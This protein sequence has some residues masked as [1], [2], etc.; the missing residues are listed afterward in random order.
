[1]GKVYKV[2]DQ[3]QEM[4]LSMKVMGTRRPTASVYFHQEANILNG[5]NHTNIIQYFGFHQT[6]DYTFLLEEFI[7]GVSLQDLII[8]TKGL[9][10]KNSLIVLK[11]LCGALQYLHESSIVHCD[12]KPGNILIDQIGQIHIIDFGLAMSINDVSKRNEVA[13]TAG[14]MSPEQFNKE[15][16]SPATDVFALGILLCVMLTGRSPIPPGKIITAKFL[17][18]SKDMGKV[19]ENG[20]WEFD[21]SISNEVI[22]VLR[23]S[24]N[25]EPSKRYKDAKEFFLGLCKAC[26]VAFYDIDELLDLSLIIPGS[27]SKII[28]SDLAPEEPYVDEEE[29]SQFTNHTKAP[30]TMARFKEEDE[31]P[32]FSTFAGKGLERHDLPRSQV[33]QRVLNANFL[34][35]YDNHVLTPNENLRPGETYR[36]LVDIGLPWNTIPSIAGGKIGFPEDDFFTY[37]TSNDREKGWFDLEVVFISQEFLPNLINGRI[38]VSMGSVQRSTPYIDNKLAPMPGPLKLTIQAPNIS[39]NLIDARAHGYLCLYY[40]VQIL[41]SAVVDVGIGRRSTGTK[42]ED[43]NSITVD[44][45][46]TR[47]E[48]ADKNILVRNRS[49]KDGEFEAPIKIGVMINNDIRGTHRILLKLDDETDDRQYLP[50]AWKAYD[51]NSV[52]ETLKKIRRVLS[53]PV[54]GKNN[55]RLGKDVFVPQTKFKDDLF[56]LAKAGAE[57]YSILFQGITPANGTSP[58][59]WRKKFRNALRPG[60]IIQLARTSTVPTTHVIPWALVYDYPVELGRSDIPIKFC[61]VVD[62]QWTGNSARRKKNYSEQNILSCPYEHEHG[63]NIICPYGFWGY[64]YVLEQPISALLSQGWDIEPARGILADAPIKMAIA[65][66]DDIPSKSQRLIH[67]QNIHNA[68]DVEY[69]PRAPAVDRD[70]LRDSIRAPHLV[71]LLC[72]GKKMN[73]V[74]CLSIGPNDEDAKHIITPELPGAWGQDNY[75][76]LEKWSENRPL[77]FI[78][79]CY[80]TDLLP[81]LTLDFVSAFRDLMAGGVIGTEIQITVEQGYKVAEI[82]F[83]N[84]GQ[85]YDVGHSILDMRWQMLNEVVLLVWHILPIVYLICIYY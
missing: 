25:K 46:L 52:S 3:E 33:R 44:Y 81:E 65:A 67:F 54:D 78:N 18:A 77:V 59:L 14:Y 50:P 56:E 63:T 6:R 23:Q 43:S 27:S 74:T 64:K 58:M 51:A 17:E 30:R 36:L 13:G 62:E 84:L 10:L 45:V 37:L 26:L 83:K 32:S 7:D 55:S 68:I 24:L 85:G 71:Y 22:Q 4:Y 2:W 76:N 79:G 57:L 1:M 8:K 34:A 12:L 53:S 28:P 60:D 47:I 5:L 49:T 73:K 48:N 42:D 21:P 40:G 38:R 61:R 35:E 11:Q 72:H 39:Q 69:N 16:I 82:F 80:T 15:E 31:I 75:I 41:Q 20:F 70:Q 9:S 66:T 29:T 19:F